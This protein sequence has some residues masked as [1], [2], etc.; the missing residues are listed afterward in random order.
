MIQED[1]AFANLGLV[2]I[3]EQHRFGV[4]QRE[5]L[6]S[7]GKVVD[8]LVMTATPIP[9]TLAMTV[10]G[11]L[12]LTIIDELPP[13]RKLPKTVLVS[14]TK[15]DQVYDFMK[16]EIKAGGQAYIV[17]PL[18]DE[19]DKIQA[20]AATQMFEHLANE[21]FKD[22]KVG[23]LHGKM[24]QQEKD[25]VMES[26]ARREI[27]ILV[28]TTVIEVGVDVPGATV[29]MI[30]NPERFG[31]AQL[32]QLRGRVGRSEKQG[33]CFLIVGNIDEEALERLRY[34]SMSKDGFEVAEYDLRLRG[35]GEFLGLR[36]HG[37]P[38]LK[39]A[40]LM[41]DKEILIQARKDAEKL[42]NHPIDSK[43]LLKKV[44]QLYGESLKLVNV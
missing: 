35:P 41:R 3:D 1:V 13:G 31:L 33:Y 37:L 2:V 21:V 34:F 44:Q 28:S 20:K 5:A 4:K 22:F 7:K 39:V 43:E 26:F 25:Q 38:D 23:L 42:L 14:S 30:E 9:R 19:S 27:E 29:M 40:D 6:I 12:D 11:D 24:T 15:I 32:H 8:T 16:N 10:Y 36:Q 17:Y 18:I